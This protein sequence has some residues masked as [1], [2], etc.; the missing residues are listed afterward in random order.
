M[1]H[2][3]NFICKKYK[4]ADSPLP[5]NGAFF[6]LYSNMG[7]RPTLPPWGVPLNPIFFF[8]HL[9]LKPPTASFAQ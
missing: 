3:L 2:I 4:S 8:I 6:L 1:A 9:E 5:Y 7:S